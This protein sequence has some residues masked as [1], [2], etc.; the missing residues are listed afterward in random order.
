MI[1]YAWHSEIPLSLSSPKLLGAHAVISQ[2]FSVA[3]LSKSNEM[4]FSL[5][6]SL[7]L[8]ET[9]GAPVKSL[10]ALWI[11]PLSVAAKD[12]WTLAQAFWIRST[13]I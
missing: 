4:R 11:Y 2:F 13:Q 12:P 5:S 6:L 7:V 8:Y 1:E 3:E 10:N 9:I